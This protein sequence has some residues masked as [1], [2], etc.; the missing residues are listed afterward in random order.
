MSY[1]ADSKESTQ[2][3]LSA[4]A[5]KIIASINELA[6]LP[7]VVFKV[8][9]LSGSLDSAASEL[10]RVITVD[11]AFSAKLLTH[12]NSSFYGLSKK[13]TSIRDA[14]VYMG[15]KA[16]REMAMH[17][18]VFDMFVGKNDKD[19]LRRRAWWRHSVDAAVCCRAIAEKTGW[20]DPAEAYT[21]GLLHYIG[22]SLL[23]RF[24][25]GDYD[26]VEQRMAVGTSET[27]AETR[28]YGCDHQ[29][30]ARGAGYKWGLPSK[31]AESFC[32]L[33]PCHS[34]DD[35]AYHRACVALG[36][37]IARHAIEGQ[38]CEAVAP[39]WALSQL[40]LDEGNWQDLYDY[41]LQAIATSAN[42]T[43]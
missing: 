5:Q 3:P 33:T 26:T 18:G 24:G 41:C 15:F 7:H 30:V 40:Q 1:L 43:F 10:E 2:Q 38:A 4:P 12:A 21:C 29:E 19:S 42:L 25:K 28:V 35:F 14:I 36:N 20:V 31:V 32:Y 13:V 11:P 6:V 27:D 39:Q 22:K 23:D 37:A 8:L 9:D 16:V 17:V 34:T